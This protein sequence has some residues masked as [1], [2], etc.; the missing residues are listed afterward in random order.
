MSRYWFTRRD[1]GLKEGESVSF[2]MGPE[3]GA[4][5]FDVQV[6]AVREPRQ[7]VIE[8]GGPDETAT[9]VTFSFDETE[10]GDTILTVEET[11]FADG[12][13]VQRV[14]DSTGGFNQVVVAAKA[15]IEHGIAVNVVADHA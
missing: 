7:I 15:F 13:V 9:Q 14:L 4:F 1:G 8:W 5:S 12:E 10:E 11:G 3:A 6:I 2:Y